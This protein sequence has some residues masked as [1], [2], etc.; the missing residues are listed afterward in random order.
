MDC[1][2]QRS[3]ANSAQIVCADDRRLTTQVIILRVLNANK[4]VIVY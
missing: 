3:S 4:G 1:K 2:A